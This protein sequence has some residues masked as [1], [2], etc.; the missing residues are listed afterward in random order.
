MVSESSDLKYFGTVQSKTGQ[1]ANYT[2]DVAG[3]LYTSAK[4]YIPDSVQPHVKAVED[5][6]SEYGSPALTTLQDKSGK[7]LQIADSK[8]R[9]PPAICRSALIPKLSMFASECGGDRDFDL[10]CC[11]RV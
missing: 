10:T 5:K 4:Q 3:K 11:F 9:S 6:V 7:F 1:A 8:V 2:T